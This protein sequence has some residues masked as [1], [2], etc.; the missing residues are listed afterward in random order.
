M[1]L[2]LNQLKLNQVTRLSVVLTTLTGSLAVSQASVADEVNIYSYRQEFLIRP[3]LDAFTEKTGVEVNVVFSSKG[4]LERLENE[5]RN[6]PADILLT[7]DIGP[8][9]DAKD[10]NLLAKI[11]SATISANVP[12][13]YR[14]EDSQW[15]GLTARSR[16]IYTSKD[17]V[18]AGEIASYEDLTDPKWAGRICTRSGK[19]SYN[20]SLI[21]SMIEHKGAAEAEAWLAAVKE[22]LARK[23][24][25]NDRA[26]VKA[27]KEG[28][29]DVALGN[30]YYFG[31]MLN[32][33][34][35]PEQK[36]WAQSVN[37]VFPN[38]DDR[39]AHMNISGAAI[40]ANAPNP[41]QALQLIEFLTSEEAQRIYAEVNHE[42]PVRP[43]VARS[44]LINEYMGEFKADTL[45]L[46]RIA[47][48][49]A[50]ASR[51]V[52]RVGFDN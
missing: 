11:E 36:E 31:A 40:T 50:E 29:C 38:Q 16:I 8:L 46:T 48:N 19:H 14:D 32:N 5:G 12:A 18:E 28:Q 34:K 33:D 25:G 45:S 47:A 41:Q 26:Q 3:L 39:G 13:Q 30:S 7:S 20:L 15:V 49:R 43:G 35:E 42:F 1:T 21:G 2:K 17:R 4:L 37:L 6:T 52:D 44:A 51:M 23:P 22:N 27:V 9:Q 24:Q 10:L